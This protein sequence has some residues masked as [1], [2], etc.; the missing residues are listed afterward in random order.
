MKKALLI[1]ISIVSLILIF[2][3]GSIIKCEIITSFH[4]NEFLVF[5]EVNTA[6]KFKIITYKDTFARLY[7]VNFNGTNG[8][9]H[10]FIKKDNVWV[11]NEWERAVWAKFGTADGIVWPYIR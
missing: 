4:G 9:V 5:G 8:S 10:N 2:W 7:C 6:S 1:I 11:Y 3:T